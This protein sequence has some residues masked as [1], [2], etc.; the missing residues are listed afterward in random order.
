MWIRINGGEFMMGNPNND[1]MPIDLESPQI[2]V[3]ISSFEI[4]DTTVTNHEF[5]EFVDATGYITEAEK[6][7][8]SFVF[9]LADI[10]ENASCCQI[11]TELPWWHLVKGAS[12]KH[13]FG[14]ESSFIEDHPVVHV[15]RND[16]IAYCEWN[17]VRLP[18]EQEWEFA[19][20]A[21]TTTTF[22]W[23]DDF[24]INGEYNANIWQG[25]FP[26][27]NTKKDGY[28]F[29]AP[30]KTYTPNNFELYQMIGNVWEWCANKAPIDL[31]TLVKENPKDIWEKNKHYSDEKYAIR[32]GSFLCHDSYCKRYKVY[33]RNSQ[34]ATSSSSNLGFRVVRDI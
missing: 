21:N 19:A 3:Y 28:L 26:S 9:H 23:G 31:E 20:R 27:L 8:D 14:S 33:S 16:A 24:L 6:F 18:T 10:S 7:G 29:T 2:K 30:V 17:G 5:K 13:P 22:P 34:F 11:H 15:S 4:Q 12:W 1:G 32:G 25:N